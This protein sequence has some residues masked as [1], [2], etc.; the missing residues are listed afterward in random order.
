MTEEPQ[1]LKEYRVNVNGNE[2]TMRLTAEEAERYG[3]TQATGQAEGGA[4][5]DTA[6]PNKAS[7]P[8]SNKGGTA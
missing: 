4:K 7:A 2:T 5:A 8:G 6:T 3:A 1:E